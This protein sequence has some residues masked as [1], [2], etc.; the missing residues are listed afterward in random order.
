MCV[1]RLAIEKDTGDSKRRQASVSCIAGFT[2]L[3]LIVDHVAAVQRWY[4]CNY[5]DD[6]DLAPFELPHQLHPYSKGHFYDAV[7]KNS[8]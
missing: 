3:K 1:S 8:Q 6:L 4:P 7:T 2:F 5:P